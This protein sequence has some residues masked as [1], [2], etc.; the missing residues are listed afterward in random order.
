MNKKV[1]GTGWLLGIVLSVALA[2]AVT[3]WVVQSVAEL[4]PTKTVVTISDVPDRFRFGCVIC[5][6]GGEYLIPG[7][8]EDDESFDSSHPPIPLDWKYCYFPTSEKYRGGLV[9][10]SYEKIGLLTIDIKGNMRARLLDG[11]GLGK[12]SDNEICFSFAECVDVREISPSEVDLSPEI[13][14][15]TER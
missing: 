13:V 4:S 2:I 3:P 11:T 5:E 9:L 1:I 10:P 12:R 15:L 7:H 6:S 8:F 14:A